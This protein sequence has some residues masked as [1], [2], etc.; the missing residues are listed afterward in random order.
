MTDETI[1]ASVQAMI[2][3]H[4]DVGPPDSVRVETRDHGVY[5]SGYVSTGLMKWT[6]EDLAQH[7]RGVTKVV[8]AVTK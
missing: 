1:T 4:P 3:Q 8:N 2:N 6:A 5:L 7:S